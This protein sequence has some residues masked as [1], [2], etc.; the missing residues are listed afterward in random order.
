[1][2][3]LHFPSR[4]ALK[5][6]FILALFA[7]C[8]TLRAAQIDLNT[9][10]PNDT[11]NTPLLS[12][13]EVNQIIAQGVGYMKAIGV[14]GVI[15]VAD[16]EGHLQAIY[17][18][19]SSASLDPRINDQATVKARTAS[20]FESRGDAFTTRTAQFIVQSNFPPGIRNV[21]AGPLFSV[22]FS[23]FPNADI[24]LNRPDFIAFINGIN[25]P[26]P[27]A[28][29]GSADMRP[30]LSPLVITP[31]TDDPGGLTVWKEGTPPGVIN[32]RASA[33]RKFPCGGVGVEI[34]GFGVL[35]NGVP[36]AGVG[37]T[38]T[39]IVPGKTK[40]LVEEAACLAAISGFEPPAVYLATTIVVNGFRFPY[41][42]A[43][44]PKFT[45]VP[46]P[47]LATDGTFQPFTDTDG[48]E[49]SASGAPLAGDPYTVD[50]VGKPRV[51]VTPATQPR[52]PQTQEIPLRGWVPRF[53]PRDSPLGAITKADV[54]QMVQQGADQAIISRA[55]IRKPKGVPVAVWITV[56]D[57]N[58]D[59][60]GLFRTEDATYFSLDICVQKARTAAFF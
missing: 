21:D 5:A 38:D 27:A 28:L 45:A 19:N 9:P 16:R 8:A 53:P 55:A 2:H 42:S 20:F 59:I 33:T 36:D 44:K 48:T 40:M 18:M 26:G 4:V 24:Q 54:I 60:C 14:S 13:A 6:T 32:P 17:R 46:V 7:M 56:V 11:S 47:E 43:R 51:I 29:A 50:F 25:A 37:R 57:L 3:S 52:G 34:D 30:M 15:A 35:A 10:I 49:R 1:M 58:G 31:L 39:G 23:N 22:P 41:V 12:V